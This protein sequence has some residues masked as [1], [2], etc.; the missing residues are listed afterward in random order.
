MLKRSSFQIKFYNFNIDILLCNFF[1]YQWSEKY[2]IWKLVETCISSLKSEIIFFRMW[3]ICTT[4]KQSFM[5]LSAISEVKEYDP[6]PPPL[7]KEK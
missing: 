5:K 1:A 3:G 4:V 2:K 7:K 6:P